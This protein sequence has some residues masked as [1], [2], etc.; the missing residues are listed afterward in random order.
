MYTQVFL[1]CA[2]NK[3]MNKLG[4]I[5]FN[6]PNEGWAD[7]STQPPTG[8]FQ[9]EPDRRYSFVWKCFIQTLSS[10]LGQY[11]SVLNLVWLSKLTMT[12]IKDFKDWNVTF[13]SCSNQF[14]CQVSGPVL[15]NL[16]VQ[17]NRK[18]LDLTSVSF[19]PFWLISW[20]HKKQWLIVFSD[21][22]IITARYAWQVTTKC[23]NDDEP[24]AVVLKWWRVA[25]QT[26]TKKLQM[27]RNKWIRR[28]RDVLSSVV[29]PRRS[30]RHDPL[31]TAGRGQM[32]LGCRWPRRRS[33]PRLQGGS[34]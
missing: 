13:V 19:M 23:T 33:R 21:K 12:M 9:R 14:F 2:L 16:N 3:R 30:P 11:N 25:G 8:W 28:V 32:P 5:S 18:L 15:A 4:K 26:W 1:S 20:K 6:Q 22:I 7:I 27:R 34:P 24:Y 29:V 31:S 17:L 10:I